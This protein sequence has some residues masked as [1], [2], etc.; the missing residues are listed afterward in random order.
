MVKSKNSKLLASFTKYAHS[1]K[2][3]RFFQC[4]RNWCGWPFVFVGLDNDEENNL[5]VG[6]EDTFYWSGIEKPKK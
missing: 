4:L 1:H 5:V 2:E 6:L 3:E